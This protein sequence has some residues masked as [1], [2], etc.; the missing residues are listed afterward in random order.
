MP[1]YDYICEHCD[2]E[3][4]AFHSMNDAPLKDCPAC[5][6]PKLKRQ[7]GLGAGIIFKGSGF[8]ETDYKRKSGGESSSD[9][10]TSKGESASDAKPATATPCGGACA[11]AGNN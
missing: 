4:E 1:T 10:K 8:Y 2:H 7:I 9:G 3:L 5:G 6:K 11:C